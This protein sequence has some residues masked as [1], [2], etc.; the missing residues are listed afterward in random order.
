ME[1][2]T[3]NKPTRPRLGHGQAEWRGH[4]VKEATIKES[5]TRTSNASKARITA[6]VPACGFAK[7]L[8][9]LEWE[10][11]FEAICHTW[12]NVPA[13]SATDVPF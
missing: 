3:G 11:P 9:A 1:H 6:F 8:E 10:T 12:I 2:G 5:Q 13:V 4:A 7:R